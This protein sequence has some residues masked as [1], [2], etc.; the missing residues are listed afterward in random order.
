MSGERRN[1]TRIYLARGMFPVWL[2][3]LLAPAVLLLFL[4]SFALLIGGGLLAALVL[5]LLWRRRSVQS[6]PKDASVIE[7]EPSEYRRI[8]GVRDR[9]REGE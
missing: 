5:P 2:L 4:F 9:R 7:L 8:E 3:L 1:G 6:V